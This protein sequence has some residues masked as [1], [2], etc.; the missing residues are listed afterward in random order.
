MAKKLKSVEVFFNK[1]IERPYDGCDA[2]STS[3]GKMAGFDKTPER[4]PQGWYNQFGE[5]GSGISSMDV[6]DEKEAEKIYKKLLKHVGKKVGNDRKIKRV[7]IK[8]WP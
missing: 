3:L 2:I 1:S 5:F 4:F 6:F 8:D 7:E